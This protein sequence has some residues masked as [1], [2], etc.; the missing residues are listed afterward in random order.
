MAT[1]VIDASVIL[2]WLLADP[3]TD[4]DTAA[5]T[6]LM[7]SLVAGQ[8]ELVQPVHWLAE[9][10]AVMARLSPETAADDVLQLRAMEWPVAD[11]AQVWTR[12][13]QLALDTRQHVFDTLYHAVALELPNATL[14]TADERYRIPGARFGRIIALRDWASE[15]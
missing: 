7:A 8:H 1:W 2:K 5:A 15:R 10:A 11:D 6:A 9:I 4:A 12:A 13:V 3:D 14:V